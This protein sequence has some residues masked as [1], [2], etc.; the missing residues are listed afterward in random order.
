MAESLESGAA[1][2]P[3]HAAL[4]YAAE[5]HGTGGEMNDG[6][7]DAASAKMAIVQDPPLGLFVFAEKY[8]A[9]GWGCSSTQRIAQ[10]TKSPVAACVPETSLQNHFVQHLSLHHVHYT[11]APAGS[12]RRFLLPSRHLPRSHPSS[13]WEQSAKSFR[14]TVRRR[15]F[16]RIHQSQQPV[17]MLFVNDFP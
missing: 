8:R 9:R 14:H 13:L 6:V 4:T 7:V 17:K 11:S 12:V 2:I 15:R 1:V 10:S 16:F 3:T 5:G